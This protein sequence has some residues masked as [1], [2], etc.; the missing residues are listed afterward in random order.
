[1]DEL[2]LPGGYCIDSKRRKTDWR[3][4]ML[5]GRPADLG[6]DRRGEGTRCVGDGC[7]QGTESGT[8]RVNEGTTLHPRKGTLAN[9]LCLACPHPNA[10]RGL[11]RTLSSIDTRNPRPKPS[12]SQEFNDYVYKSFTSE[13]KS[14]CL[15][16]VGP[17]SL[18]KWL[19][20][21]SS[22]KDIKL[23]PHFSKYVDIKAAFKSQYPGKACSSV[24]DMVR[25]LLITWIPKLM[26][27]VDGCRLN[28]WIVTKCTDTP[29]N[30]STDTDTHTQ[31]CDFVCVIV[32]DCVCFCGRSVCAL[33]WMHQAVYSN[34][35]STSL[36]PKLPPPPSSDF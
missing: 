1:M 12:I 17:A 14:F 2:C 16:A 5:G 28:F 25:A 9:P 27:D 32:R 22:S 24:A 7:M 33:R 3:K 23:S 8:S 10:F 15:A 4:R 11:S 35:E 19:R 21:D 29:V 26:Q 6:K 31:M 36:L 30:R 20:I 34:L 18:K 13:N